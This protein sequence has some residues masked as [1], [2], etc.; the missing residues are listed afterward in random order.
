MSYAIAQTA[1][2]EWLCVSTITASNVNSHNIDHGFGRRVR[3]IE[4][5]HNDAGIEAGTDPGGLFMCSVGVLS[6]LVFRLVE[7]VKPQHVDFRW[8]KKLVLYVRP[9]FEE[10]TEVTTEGSASY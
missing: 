4:L 2:Y 10:E 9:G 5:V 6:I 7:E 3:K 8:S 1:D